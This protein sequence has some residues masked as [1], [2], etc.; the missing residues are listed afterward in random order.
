MG[1]RYVQTVNVPGVWGRSNVDAFTKAASEHDVCIVNQLELGGAMTYE[2]VVSALAAFK[3]D[4][5][6]VYAE[7]DDLRGLLAAKKK[8]GDSARRCVVICTNKLTLL[9]FL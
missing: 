4:V 9:Y 1:W 6:V 3:T 8:I 7:F 2:N 5:V